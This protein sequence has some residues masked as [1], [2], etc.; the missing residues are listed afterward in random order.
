[1]V[2][3]PYATVYLGLGRKCYELL[4]SWGSQKGGPNRKW[5]NHPC[6]GKKES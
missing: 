2:T 6:L 5:L 4:R 3:W 1:M